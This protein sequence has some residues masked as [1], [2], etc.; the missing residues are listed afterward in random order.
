MR[1]EVDSDH[2]Y[3][4]ADIMRRVGIVFPAGYTDPCTCVDAYDSLP[5]EVRILQQPIFD[6]D[7]S[8]EYKGRSSVFMNPPYS[9]KA[10]TAGN[11]VRRLTDLLDDGLSIPRVAIVLVNAS[12]D[13]EWW[14]E[15]YERSSI[16]VLVRGRVRFERVENGKRVAPKSPRHASSIHLLF[17]HPMMGHEQMPHIKGRFYDAFDMG[18]IME[19]F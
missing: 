3:T 7:F 5:P 16:V 6:V 15:L 2:W 17:G 13:T 1:I 9:H 18:V 8:D 14:Q 11:F 4:P 12:T 10:G 19:P